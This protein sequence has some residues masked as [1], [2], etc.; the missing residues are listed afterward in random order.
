MQETEETEQGHP[1][2]V[3]TQVPNEVSQDMVAPFSLIPA[4]SNAGDV[5]DRI[6]PAGVSTCDS[7]TAELPFKFDGESKNVNIFCEN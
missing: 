1:L 2:Q 4:H 6:I 5:L 7:A 3:D